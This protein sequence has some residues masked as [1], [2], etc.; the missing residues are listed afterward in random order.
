MTR[1]GARTRIWLSCIAKVMRTVLEQSGA[2][3][4]LVHHAH[5]AALCIEHGVIEFLTGDRDFARFPGL[6][7][8]NPYPL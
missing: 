3:G 6:T 5:I 8:S 4:N 1:L 7:V 2:T